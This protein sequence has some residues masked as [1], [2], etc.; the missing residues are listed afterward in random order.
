MGR[1]QVYAVCENSP[2]WVGD[3]TIAIARRIVE[4]DMEAPQIRERAVNVLL[5]QYDPAT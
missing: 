2:G 1:I 4:N 3:S 5:T